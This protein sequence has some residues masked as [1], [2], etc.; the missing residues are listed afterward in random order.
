[1][2]VLEVVWVNDMDGFVFVD[3]INFYLFLFI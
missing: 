2:E 1:M 3:N